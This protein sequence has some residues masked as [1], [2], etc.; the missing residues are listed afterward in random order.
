MRAPLEAVH[1]ES[2]GRG[3]PIRLEQVVGRVLRYG[4]LLSVALIAVGVVLMAASGSFGS[5]GIPQSSS[6]ELRPPVHSMV[7]LLA[8]L[9][10]GDPSALVSL[11]LLVLIATPVARVAT[12][13]VYFLFRR[14]RLYLAI[15]SFVLLV[16]IAGFLLGAT[17]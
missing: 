1:P 8:G 3:R 6:G 15:T 10:G 12:T 2:P 16:L 11:G 7:G 4:S 9:Q 14:D 5:L 13:V 17:E